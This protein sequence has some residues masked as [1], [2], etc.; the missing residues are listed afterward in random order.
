M[1]LNASLHS[2]EQVTVIL[3]SLAKLPSDEADQLFISQRIGKHIR[4]IL[5]HFDAVL[6][7]L[8]TAHIDYNQRQRESLAERDRN[9]AHIRLTVIRDNWPAT[10][11]LH[12]PV[13][14][15]SEVALDHQH[16]EAFDS[17]LARECLY[18]VNHTVHHVAYIKLLL[19]HAGVKLPANIGIAPATASFER[20]QCAH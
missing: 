9:A 11:S 5:D 17:S 8:K 1:P 3:E 14:V 6:T 18:L 12:M 10:A 15:L 20:L 13:T 4:H 7:G 19:T 16:S 2:L